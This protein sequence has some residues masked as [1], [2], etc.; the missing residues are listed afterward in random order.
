[1][2]GRGLARTAD[3]SRRG[4]PGWY[5]QEGPTGRASR[6]KQPG[7]RRCSPI[8]GM[9]HRQANGGEQRTQGPSPSPRPCPSC[10]DGHCLV[11]IQP[12]LQPEKPSLEERRCRSTRKGLQRRGGAEPPTQKPRRPPLAH[13]RNTAQGGEMFPGPPPSSSRPSLAGCTSLRVGAL[14]LLLLKN[15]PLMEGIKLRK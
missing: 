10:P 8:S 7:P 12:C 9:N 14:F 6:P 13:R 2:P 5:S 11:P 3:R 1:M 15:L 4:G